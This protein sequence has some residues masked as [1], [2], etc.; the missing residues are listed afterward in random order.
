MHVCF[1]LQPDMIQG[2]HILEQLGQGSFAVVYK[3]KKKDGTL[4][5][6][7]QLQATIGRRYHKGELDIIDLKLNHENIVR[8]QNYFTP[9]QSTVQSI[10][11]VMELCEA[12]DLAHYYLVNNPNLDSRYNFML[13]MAKGVCFLHNHGI[14]HRDLKPENILLKQ[15]ERGLVC[16][17]SDFGISKI[18]QRRDEMFMTQVGSM[19]YMAPEMIDQQDHSKPV[20]IFALGLLFFV[21][22]KRSILTNY[23]GEKAL[24]PGYLDK[25]N[26]ITYFN[27]II[28]KQG[29]NERSFLATHFPG[30]KAVGKVIIS[31]IKSDPKKRCEIEH[32]LVQTTDAKV[33]NEVQAKKK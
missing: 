11:I 28:H 6:I 26:K 21:A 14:V 19:A 16:K 23:F 1:S 12:G 31:M 33:R 13:D 3:G 32:V 18:Q 20:D 7:K 25:Q 17:I 9:Q 10:T 27:S 22:F 24:I 4:V 30:S 15:L 5:A 8:V 2:Y 29:L